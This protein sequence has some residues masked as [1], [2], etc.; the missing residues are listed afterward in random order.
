MKMLNCTFCHTLIDTSEG[1]VFKRPHNSLIRC[2]VCR[3]LVSTSLP[4]EA[5]ILSAHRAEYY[6]DARI[7]SGNEAEDDSEYLHLAV[8]RDAM[9]RFPN[10]AVRGARLLDFGCGLG[11]FLKTANRMGYCASG[12][13]FC[14]P[15]ADLA[16]ATALVPVYSSIHDIDPNEQFD[17]ITCFSVVEHLID[18]ECALQQLICRLSS[19]GFIEITVPNTRSIGLALRREKWF[20]IVNPT[21]LSIPSRRGLS[22]MLRRQGLHCRRVILRGGHRRPLLAP[23]Q[24]LARLTGT[25]SELRVVATRR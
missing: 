16:R 7:A 9:R 3:S 22:L 6:N 14:A 5:E 4:T 25:G 15:A 20:N 1:V 2:R 23:L 17:I 12:V 19:T 24:M 10:L 11:H 13:E 8:I 21:H 18:P